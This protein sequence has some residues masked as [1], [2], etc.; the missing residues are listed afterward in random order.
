MGGVLLVLVSFGE[1]EE[2][3]CEGGFM[4]GRC[5]CLELRLLDLGQCFGL[6]GD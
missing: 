3:R 4:R 1:S 2:V 5:W 6:G